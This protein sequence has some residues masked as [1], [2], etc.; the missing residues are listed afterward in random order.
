MEIKNLISQLE[1]HS[2]RRWGVRQL[3]KISRIIIHQ[4]LGDGSIE[5]VNAYHI[6]PNHISPMGCPRICYHYG[7]RK[8]GEIV[9]M[10]ELSSVVW[11]TKGQN[12]KAIGIMLVGNFAGM[13]HTA[14]T[15]EP[16]KEQIDSL[17]FLCDY[18]LKA[19][20]FSNQ[21]LYGHYHYGKPAC[22]GYFVSEWIENKRNTITTIRPEYKDVEKTVK[23]IQKR[24]AKLGYD[25]GKAD[26]IQ[27]MKTIAA[28]RKF[29]M[30]N[31]LLADGIVG[32]TTWKNLLA[33]TS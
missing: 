11:H 31:K 14:A 23:E 9:Q 27:G 32:P 20:N 24:L 29:Q 16:S 2:T 10:N 30:D 18:L 26:G 5:E 6:K 17:N 21:E 3:S 13:G 28:I 12:S 8:N 7:I 25:T 15:G 1:W 22:P 33:F 19:F 4:E